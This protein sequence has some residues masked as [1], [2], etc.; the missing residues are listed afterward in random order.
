MIYFDSAATT[1]LIPEVIEKMTSVMKEYYGNPSSLHSIGRKAKAILENSRR[2]I[3]QCINASPREIIF[4]SGGTEGN[5]LV[6]RSSITHDG[7]QR[8]I[9]TKIEHPAVIKT[10]QE[11][12]K[13]GIEIDYVSLTSDGD[14]DLDNLEKKLYSP[15]KTLISIMHANNEIGNINNI[16][17][18][19]TLAKKHK[20][21]FHCDTVQT[22]GKIPLDMRTFPADFAVCSAHKIH[23]PKGVGFLWIKNGKK[24]SSVITGGGQER[25]SRAGTENLYG[26]AGLAKAFEIAHADIDKNFTHIQ[27]LKEYA[28]KTTSTRDSKHTIQWEKWRFK[29]KHAKHH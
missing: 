28:K 26:I 15:K 25:N 4:T 17:A 18:I 12:E 21:C 5:N 19:G 1:C 24:V 6:L 3:A 23:G 22:M 29:N 13:K 9:T 7:S 8:I 27:N 10:V 11:L 14:I 2:T 20:A 16:D